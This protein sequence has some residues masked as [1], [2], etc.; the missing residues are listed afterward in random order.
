MKITKRKKRGGLKLF[1]TIAKTGQK[2][3]F[4]R[5][6]TRAFTA[7]NERIAGLST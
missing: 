4:E 3:K 2:L 6:R 5:S 1:V 7:T